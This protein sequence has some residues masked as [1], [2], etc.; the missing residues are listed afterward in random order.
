MENCDYISFNSARTK[1][2]RC[3]SCPSISRT[4]MTNEIRLLLSAC[5]EIRDRMTEDADRLAL[6]LECI[7]RQIAVNLLPRQFSPLTL[8]IRNYIAE[9]LHETIT[10]RDVGK[11]AFFSP[12]YC[13]SVFRRETGMSIVDY[14]IDEKMKEAKK[15]IIEG[16]PLKRVAE[17]LGFSDYNYFSPT[18]KNAFPIPLCNIGIRCCKWVSFD[19]SLQTPTRIRRKFTGNR[20]RMRGMCCLPLVPLCK[21]RCPLSTPWLPCVKTTAARHPHP[22][23]LVQRELSAQLTEGL[24]AR[25]RFAKKAVGATLPCPGSQL[26]IP[27]VTS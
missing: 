27:S 20:P 23:S 2:K 13:S 1:G 8:R 3:P 10:L 18:F 26:L 14:A 11:A 21:N 7:L 22:G 17:M 19:L 24:S 9:H 12:A 16:L 6:I 25:F 15:L 5:D 4:A